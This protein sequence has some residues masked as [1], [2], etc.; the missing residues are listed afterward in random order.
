MSSNYPGAQ[1]SFPTEVDNISSAAAAQINNATAAIASLEKYGTYIFNARTFGGA[2]GDNSTDDT[3]ALQNTINAA[4]AVTFGKAVV[5]LPPGVYLYSSALTIPSPSMILQGSGGRSSGG[6]VATQL[7]YTG[8][9]GTRAIDARSTIGFSARDI[10]FSAVSTAYAGISLDLASSSQS[11]IRNCTFTFPN[12]FASG[13]IGINWDSCTSAR[14]QAC[15]FVN[16]TVQHRLGSAAQCHQCQIEGCRYLVGSTGITPIQGTCEGLLIAG[17]LVELS[18]IASLS[19]TFIN[20]QSTSVA[21]HLDNV[22]I[23]DAG[24]G[25]TYT[26]VSFTGTGFSMT[27]CEI[28]GINTTTAV[29]IGNGSQAI[30]IDSSND[31]PGGGTAVAL[32]TGITGVH[33][34]SF[35]TTATNRF[36]GTPGAGSLTIASGNMR[37]Y[38]AL[39][40]SSQTPTETVLV[41]GVD[42][43]AGEHVEVTLS[44]AR[45]VG[46]PLNPATGQHLYFTLIQNGTGGFA[47][48]WSAA[49]KVSW[50]DTGN[51]ANK[52]STIGFWYDGTSWNQ[53]GAQTPYV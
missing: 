49:F 15:T 1:D 2:K 38:E 26:G 48:T 36:T 31:F 53:I 52:R 14:I 7:N 21:V 27:A 45:L 35:A 10:L 18:N 44:A 17:S 20:L 37:V 28:D 11:D 43:T 8:T 23:L 50:S 39:Q 12:G 34:G 40:R 25:S 9:T 41:S 29:S 19:A 16:G 47:V 33:L 22:V 32:G 42:A 24:T 3:T 51:T 13:A 5:Y 30:D 4:A 46:A 6:V